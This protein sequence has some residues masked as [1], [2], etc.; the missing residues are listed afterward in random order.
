M[1]YEKEINE[2]I[3]IMIP[4]EKWMSDSDYVEVVELTLKHIGTDLQAISSDIEKGI[5][6]GYSVESQI[7]AL[8]NLKYLAK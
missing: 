3:A 7:E 2:I 4:K 1:K 5:N 8:K 6:N